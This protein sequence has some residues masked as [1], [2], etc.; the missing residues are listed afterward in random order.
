MKIY[1]ERVVE[2]VTDRVCDV[3]KK[4]LMNEVGGDKYEK[5]AELKADWG[6]GSKNDGKSYHLDLCENCF[7]V[8][9]FALREHHRG[10]HMF[11]DDQDVSDDDFGLVDD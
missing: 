8:A 10:I 4:S 7:R 9:L 6:Y 2:T 1:E 11:D 5:C 3:C